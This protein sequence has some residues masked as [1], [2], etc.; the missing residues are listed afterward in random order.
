MKPIGPLM[1]EH[2][3]IERMVRVIEQELADASNLQ[4]IEPPFIETVV[5]FFRI[6]ADRTHHGKEEDI[7]F[8]ALSRKELRDEHRTMMDD[9]VNEH[10]TARENVNNLEAA[11]EKYVSGNEDAAADVMAALRRLVELY[12]AHI[13]KE[14]NSFFYPS[15]DYLTLDEEQAMLKEFYEFDRSMIHERYRKSVEKLEQGTTE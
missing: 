11:Y 15:M 5:D 9:L 8:E 4:T 13:D 7:L 1:W 6:Y 2:R 3:L 12:P 10:R 14:D